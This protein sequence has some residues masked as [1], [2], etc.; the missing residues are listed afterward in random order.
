MPSG[1]QN[2]H[3]DQALTDVSVMYS[4]ADFVAEEVMP[5]IPVDFKTN[6]YHVYGQ[7]NFRGDDDQVEA[8]AEADESNWSLSPD[9]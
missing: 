2:V 6:K 1:T 5:V 7:E 4:N 9:S 8:G 3:V